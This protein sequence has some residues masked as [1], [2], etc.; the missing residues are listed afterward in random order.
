M[1][2]ISKLTGRAQNRTQESSWPH[3]MTFSHW[4]TPWR[5]GIENGLFSTFFLF[6]SEKPWL[7]SRRDADYSDSDR[8]P[9]GTDILWLRPGLPFGIKSFVLDHSLMIFWF[10]FIS[11]FFGWHTSHWSYPEEM[12]KITVA[13][14]GITSLFI[15]YYFERCCR[16]SPFMVPQILRLRSIG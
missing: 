4:L 7:I 16:S 5:L 2:P 10:W 14:C 11:S 3:R 15:N 12:D 8:L 6:P 13:F 9:F 1:L